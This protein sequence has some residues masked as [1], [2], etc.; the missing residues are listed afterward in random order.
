MT[1]GHRISSK[2]CRELVLKPA[3]SAKKSWGGATVERLASESLTQP[4]TEV[5]LDTF[6]HRSRT[7]ACRT[8]HITETAKTLLSEG[9]ELGTHGPTNS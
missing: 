5:D 6:C 4:K 7:N 2:Y 3:I 9:C 8:V 1:S